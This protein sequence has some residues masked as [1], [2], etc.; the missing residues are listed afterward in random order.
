MPTDEL[1]PLAEK[2]L[3]VPPELVRTAV[4]LELSDGAVIADHVGETPC[5]FLA[6]LHR[7]E[8]V[9]ADRLM[10]LLSGSLPWPRIDLDNALP[11]VEQHIGLTLAESQKTALRSALVSK[12]LVITGGPMP[13]VNRKAVWPALN[14][15][16]K[17]ASSAL[18]D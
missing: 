1:I 10:R 5:V 14:S 7:A 6:G 9:I 13:A 12:V 8:R 15:L 2:L 17:P 18:L 11:W 4:D 16:R 3:E